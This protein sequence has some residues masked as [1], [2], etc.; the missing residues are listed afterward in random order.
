MAATASPHYIVVGIDGTSSG[1]WR[2]PDGSNS[3]VYRFVHDFNYGSMGVDR[4]FLD[5]PS[6]T[7]QGRETEPILQK[8]HDFVMR[9]IR[10]LFPQKAAGVKPLE[11]FDVNACMRQQ[12]YQQQ[13]GY[14][15]GYGSYTSTMPAQPLKMP[16]VVTPQMM[17]QQTFNTSELRV[18]I[19]GH[20]RGG[21]AATVLARMLAPVVKVYFLGLYDSVDRQP[22]L[23]GASVENVKIVYHARRSPEVG[24]RWYF[25]NTSTRYRAEHVEERFFNTSHGGMGG[26]YVINGAEVPWTGDSSCIIRPDSKE[27]YTE[28]G[29]VTVDNRHALTK[30]LHKPIEQICAEASSEADRFVREGAK[31]FGLPVR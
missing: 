5:G 22:C 21:L 12:Y 18:V 11:M 13:S 10:Q 3:H 30:K 19:V 24:S 31:R 7:M 14:G 8:A 2:L 17:R 6:D 25:S 27:I 29:P 23:D 20:S 28:Y 9:R 26:S 1:D 16:R 15:Y 4:L